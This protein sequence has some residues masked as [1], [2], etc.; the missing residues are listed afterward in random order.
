MNSLIFRSLGL[1]WFGLI[2]FHSIPYNLHLLAHVIS[3]HPFIPPLSAS[4]PSTILYFSLSYLFRYLFFS[5]FLSFFLS[6]LI[7]T[8]QERMEFV[9][10]Y[11]EDH[12]PYANMCMHTLRVKRT[13]RKV[14]G[15]GERGYQERWGGV[16][17]NSKKASNQ[18]SFPLSP[19]FF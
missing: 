4:P 14:S 3:V 17:I 12:P 19:L 18:Y 8:P 5:F 2:P 11:A 15:L 13:C 7:S 1:I 10:S 6:Y 9:R 16:L